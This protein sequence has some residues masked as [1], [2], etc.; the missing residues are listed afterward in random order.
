MK[1]SAWAAFGLLAALLNPSYA[2]VNG[3]RM[4]MPQV[5][6]QL[7]SI[8]M[9]EIRAGELAVTKSKDSETLRF[10]RL[11]MRDHK[12]ADTQLR[13]FARAHDVSLAGAVPDE[14]AVTMMKEL[15]AAPAGPDFDRAFAESMKKEHD[16]ALALLTSARRSS[17][18]AR[19]SR[20]L[21]EVTPLFQQHESLAAKLNMRRQG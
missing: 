19:L 21:D 20:L 10:A 8:D 15:E 4:T 16:Q 14:D 17:T 18:D 7:H 2:A 1:T 9:M 11:L 5:A 12:L 13:K 6:A 3:A